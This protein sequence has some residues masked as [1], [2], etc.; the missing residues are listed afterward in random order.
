MV[1][2]SRARGPTSVFFP[3]IDAA[4]ARG[5]IVSVVE[6]FLALSLNPFARGCRRNPTGLGRRGIFVTDCSVLKC[7]S[8]CAGTGPAYC[9]VLSFTRLVLSRKHPGTWG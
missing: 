2:R 6:I 8:L 1:F 4:G 9:L 7:G 3:A 5:F